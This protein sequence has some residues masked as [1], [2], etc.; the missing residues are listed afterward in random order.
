M[1]VNKKLL[2]LIIFFLLG[3]LLAG[4]YAWLFAGLPSAEIRPDQLQSPS[5]RITDQTGRLLY[6]SF[7]TEGGRHQ[8]LLIKQIPRA[9]IEATLAT[10]DSHFY[11]NPGVDLEGILRAA[12]TN[13]LGGET[14]AGGSTIT[15]QVARNLLMSAEERGQRTL[16]RKLR[17]S[18]LAWQLTRRYSKDEILAFYLNQSYY[19]GM[20]Y[21]VEAAAQTYFAKPVSD[22]SLAEC[23]LL[24]GLPQAPALY[25]PFSDPQAALTRRD[26]VLGLMEKTGYLT[27]DQRELT[28][29]E[30]LVLTTEPYPMEAPHFA[31]MVRA[32]VDALFTPAEIAASGGLTVRTTLNLDAQRAAEQAIARQME[33]LKEQGQRVLGYNL[34]NAALVALDPRTGQILAMVGSPDDQDTAHHGAINMAIVPRQPGSALKP[35][36]YA[37]TFDPTRAH[38]WTPATSILDVQTHFVTHDNQPYTPANYD[39]LEHGP[40]LVRQALAS[41]LNIPAV[42]ALR[43]IGLPRLFD[44]GGQ[45]GLPM[46]ADPERYDLSLAL[47]G[48]EVPLL[49]LTAAYGAFANTGFRVE[50]YAIEEIRDAQGTVLY[51]HR[52][53][54][55]QRVLDERVAW[56]ITDILSDDAARQIGFGRNSI[57]NLDRPAAV[58]TGTTTNYHDNWTIGY[59]PDLVVGVWAGNASHEAMRDVNGLTG[60]APIWHQAMRAILSGKPA[61]EFTRPKGLVQVEICT[62]SG[63]LPSPACPYKRQEW[64]IVGTEPTTPDTWY[65]TVLLDSATGHL[66]DDRTPTDRRVPGVAVDLPPTAQNWARTNGLLLWNDLQRTG[67]IPGKEQTTSADALTGAD[68]PGDAADSLPADTLQLTSPAPLTTYQITS[69]LPLSDQRIALEATGIDN[70]S[71]VT[72]MLDGQAIATL[73]APPYRAWWQLAPGKHQAWVEAE[74]IDGEHLTSSRVEFEVLGEK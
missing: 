37:A 64:F 27:T 53:P 38:P 41:S 19:G 32:Q 36:I 65:R 11:T 21:G 22:L 42:L 17:E 61:H 31:L 69:T 12:W 67:S 29:R 72:L 50:P 6:E 49:N 24:A 52:Q 4:G 59:T 68:R 20:A 33:R 13:L 63:L 73:N 74:T 30:A 51:Q 14:L 25:D 54:E 62:L 3:G 16:R 47:G 26:I 43:E 2:V 34:N 1:R 45:L 5:V 44:L 40:V 7:P 9:L 66:A 8:V 35:I 55:P 28:S 39:G 70:L 18:I 60:A 10:E 58:K 23:A 71:S 56:L 48:G 46:P 57:L 15:Q